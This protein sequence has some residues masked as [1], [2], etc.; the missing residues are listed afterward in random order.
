LA[1]TADDYAWF[2]ERPHGLAEA[3]CLTLARGLTPAEFLARIGARAER[4]PLSGV[5]A[6]FE[7]SMELWN[8]FPDAGMLIG[9]T[10]LAAGAAGAADW[11]MGVEVNGFLGVTPELIAPL[12]AGTR[13]VS[14][15]SNLSASRFCWAEDAQVRLSF[16]TL[17]PGWREGDTPDA[18]L[19]DMREAGFDLSDDGDNTGHPNESAFALA[20]R[21]TG[22]RVTAELLERASY[23]CGIAPVPG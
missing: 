17:F 9:V 11:T 13:A 4:A 1:A 7:P 18:L 16:E 8:D 23:S 5:G 12:S 10:T 22:V 3:Y 14:H 2:A 21:L 20:E 6:L 19:D 15:F